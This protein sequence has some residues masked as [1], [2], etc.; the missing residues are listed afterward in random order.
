MTIDVE[1]VLNI[2]FQSYSDIFFFVLVMYIYSARTKLIIITVTSRNCVYLCCV[3][4]FGGRGT[5]RLLSG[6]YR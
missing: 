1:I 5:N 2:I 4:V 3:I 6:S